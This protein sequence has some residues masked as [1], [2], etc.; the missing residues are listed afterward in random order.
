M[1]LEDS[2]YKVKLGNNEIIAQEVL[3]WLGIYIDSKLT[4][5][6]HV[7]KKI[8]IATR[9]FHQIERL[10]NTERGLSFQ[11]MRQLYIACCCSIADYGVPIW[12]AGQ[13]NLLDRYQ[14]LQNQALLKILG[15]FKGSP[16]RAMEIEASLPPPETRLN[17]ICRAYALRTI[18][19]NKQHAI[20]NRLPNSFFLN[21]G[22]Y[23]ENQSRFLGWKDH[24]V[25][26]KATI[27]SREDP[28]Y[29]P[30]G[31]T[32]KHPTQLIK[33][34]SMIAYRPWRTLEQGLEAL[35]NDLEDLI[36]INIPDLSKEAQALVHKHLIGQ[37]L[38]DPL[39]NK[40]IIYTD[41][42]QLESG[43]NGAGLLLT[44]SNFSDQVSSAWNLGLECEVYDA[45]LYAIYKALQMGIDKFKLATLDLWIFSDSQ[46]ALKG[47]KKGLNRANQLLYGKIYGLAR[48]IK[49]KGINIYFQWVPG[50]MGIYG[51]EK[52]DEAA[53]YG[54]K[55]LDPIVDDFGLSISYLNRKLKE[56]TLQDWQE[57]WEKVTPSNYYKQFETR[58]SLRASHLQLTKQTWSTITQLKL[59]HGYFR[60]FLIRL[61]TYEEDTCPNCHLNQKETPSHLLL[62]CPGQ[63]ESRNQ[64]INKLDKKDR[65]LYYLFKTKNGQEKLI[66]FLQDSKIATRKWLLCNLPNTI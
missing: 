8:T 36:E 18:D 19:F 7:A 61:P 39:D 11:A 32:K 23:I 52:A 1:D 57:I 58:P 50:H 17:K 26:T 21:Q 62:Y 20:K 14:K 28:D 40:V 41:G 10:S 24:I 29:R 66:Q 15:A 59:A 49:R 2:R 65:S 63:L 43:F 55:W 54:A 5:K 38:Q 45:E 3:K 48:E 51:N 22:N 53:K 6:D 33:I 16:I 12:W 9:I 27:N 56:K 44:N 13:K 37:W 30:S 4:F 35:D 64:S 34:L 42:S 31:R 25:P 60:S 47:L 46:A